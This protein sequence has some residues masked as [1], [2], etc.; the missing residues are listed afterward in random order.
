MTE[1]TLRYNPFEAKASYEYKGKDKPIPKCMGTGENSR[2]QDWLYDFFPNLKEMHNWGDGSECRLSFHGTPGD[3]EDIIHAGEVF[4][5]DNPGIH[6]SIDHLNK[7]SK[8]LNTRL[9]DLRAIFEKMQKESP[10][11]ELT[12]PSLRPGFEQALSSEF[13]ISV[14]ATVS[15]GK[16]TLINGILGQEILPARNE[17]TTAKIAQIHDVE[18]AKGWTVRGLKKN[19]N[20][21]YI[22]ATDEKSATLNELEKLNSS[23]DIDKIEIKGNIPGINSRQMRLLL[24]DTPGP[25]NSRTI[26]HAKHINDLITADYKPMIMYILNATQLEINDDKSLLEKIATAMEGSGKQGA[27]R[28]LFVL[29]KADELDPDKNEF[30]EKKVADSKDYLERQFGIRGARIFPVSAQLAK[31]IRMSQ[32]GRS[33]TESE[34]DFLDTKKKRFIQRKERHFSDYVS[35]SPSCRKKQEEILQNAIAGNDENTQ[36]LVYSGL[37]AIEL[38]MDEYLEKYAITAKISKAVGVFNNIIK[39]L[40]LKNKTEADLAANEGERK[41]VASE[42]KTLRSHIENGSEAKKLK[43]KF[44]GDIVSIKMKL[45]DG[46]KKYETAINKLSDKEKEKYGDDDEASQEKARGIIRATKKNMHL[47]YEV[48]SSDLSNLF[49]KELKNQAR[50]YL[51]EYQRYISGLVKN[52]GFAFS[53]TLNLIKVAIPDNADALLEKFSDTKIVTKKVHHTGGNADKR[54]YKPWTWF[55]EDYYSYYEDVKTEKHIIK[56][57]LLFDKEIEP[58]FQ[59]F[60]SMIKD[61]KSITDSNARR[62]KDFFTKEIGRLDNALKEAVRKEEES[63]KSQESIERQIEA[64]KTKAEWLKRFIEELD[65]VLEV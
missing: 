1:I 62:L 2:L 18:D 51:D 36:A 58:R 52:E 31:V 40:D 42:L 30:I 44:D 48:L 29:N 15:S 14:I 6:I 7:E 47:Q 50:S 57:K 21:E 10:Y 43:E 17:A 33:L 64:N 27:D 28:F 34:E 38:A 12:D 20:D 5:K 3:L 60:F 37:P 4:S 22:P 13:E 35:L 65:T 23:N 32:A 54:W 11:A 63:V 39:R 25:N 61:A 53:A 9:S 55:D 16:S 45:D 41:K 8:S 46:F 26:E 19:A 59:Q 56:M 49:E 24:S